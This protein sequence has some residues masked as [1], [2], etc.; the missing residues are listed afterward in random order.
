[1]SSVP[2]G[3]YSSGCRA[4]RWV[5]M[6]RNFT[7]LLDPSCW[8][9]SVGYLLYQLEWCQSTNT[10]Y[11][12][13]YIRFDQQLWLC[14]VK[15][16]LG[17]DSHL[18]VARGTPSENRSYCTRSRCRVAGPFEHGSIE[19]RNQS[20]GICNYWPRPSSIEAARSLVDLSTSL[21]VNDDSDSTV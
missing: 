21:A 18:E 8:P 9:Y 13:G 1:M 4:R 14:Q 10:V 16:C 11:L 3:Y 5:F 17:F 2:F 20:R 6:I 7:Q 19:S 15:Q 12:R